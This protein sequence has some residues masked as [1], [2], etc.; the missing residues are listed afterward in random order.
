MRAGEL[1]HK[2]LLELDPN[3]GVIHFVGQRAL[4]LDGPDNCFLEGSMRKR[5][6]VLRLAITLTLAA[7]LL[8][9]AMVLLISTAVL[10]I[11]AVPLVAVAVLVALLVLAARSE[12]ARTA[13]PQVDARPHR[14]PLPRARARVPL[15]R[16]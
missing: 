3:G 13:G 11:P 5:D 12:H 2:E 7:I 14:C 15:R 4:L 1:D 8:P 9:L 6:I 16:T 10:L